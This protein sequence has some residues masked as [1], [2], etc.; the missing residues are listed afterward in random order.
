MTSRRMLAPPDRQPG[1]ALG[2]LNGRNIVAFGYRRTVPAP[3]CHRADT[4]FSVGRH[5][6]GQATMPQSVGDVP[7]SGLGTDLL[8]SPKSRNLLPFHDTTVFLDVGFYPMEQ[9]RIERDRAIIAAIIFRPLCYS[10][11]NEN[12]FLLPIESTPIQNDVI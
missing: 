10:V 5:P 7:Y 3:S 8:Q 6:V 12:L 1:G 11:R 9:S 4:F 2:A